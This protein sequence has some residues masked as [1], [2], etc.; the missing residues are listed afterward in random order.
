[1]CGLGVSLGALVNSVKRQMPALQKAAIMIQKQVKT[2][3][4]IGSDETGARVNGEN[5]LAVGVPDT[6]VGVYVHS[7]TA[8][9]GGTQNV[10][11]RCPASRLG[12]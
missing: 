5:S 1:M 8:D 7:P 2:A 3:S 11:G 9:G 12:E 6:S 4:V 10:H